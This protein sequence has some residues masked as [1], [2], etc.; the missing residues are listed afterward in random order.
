MKTT[1]PI[2]GLDVEFSD[3]KPTRAGAYWWSF[4]PNLAMPV[5]LNTTSSGLVVSWNN[6]NIEHWSGLWST[7]PLVPAVEVEKA[8]EEGWRACA[9]TDCPTAKRLDEWDHSRARRVVE[10][11]S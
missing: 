11:V 5:S 7:S 8:W 4:G 1:I 6:Q 9:T 3:K 2:N 10:G